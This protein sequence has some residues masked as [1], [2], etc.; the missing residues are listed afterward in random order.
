M[1]HRAQS[2]LSD[3]VWILDRSGGKPDQ[4][5]VDDLRETFETISLV[6]PGDMPEPGAAPRG[7]NPFLPSKSDLESKN[8]G[9][10]GEK[11]LFSP[12]NGL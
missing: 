2:V 7:R 3:L 11:P 12:Q 6:S 10:C 1:R 8:N 9:K 5:E 4:R